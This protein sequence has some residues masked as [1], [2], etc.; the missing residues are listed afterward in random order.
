[1]QHALDLKAIA[2]L[3]IKFKFHKNVGHIK[4]TY[5]V[6]VWGRLLT[7]YTRVCKETTASPESRGNDILFLHESEKEPSHMHGSSCCPAYE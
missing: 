1:V 2:P 3:I 5:I 4:V 6:N 7:Q